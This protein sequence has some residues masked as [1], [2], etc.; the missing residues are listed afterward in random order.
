MLETPFVNLINFALLVSTNDARHHFVVGKT[1][2]LLEF[3]LR[4]AQ[5]ISLTGKIIDGKK[6][7]KTFLS[8]IHQKN[9]TYLKCRGLMVEWVHQSTVTL[10]HLMQQ[11]IIYLTT[12]ILVC[13][14]L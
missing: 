1:K 7:R 12:S 10:G 3:G 14:V 9:L 11:G 8:M 6:I 4:R 2:T 5:V 13:L